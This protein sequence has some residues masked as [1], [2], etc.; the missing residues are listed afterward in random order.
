VSVNDPVAYTSQHVQ[1]TSPTDFSATSQPQPPTTIDATTTD[2][3]SNDTTTGGMFSNFNASDTAKQY[4]PQTVVGALQNAGFIDHDTS[5]TSSTLPSQETTF[6]GSRGGVGTLPGSW[7]EEGVAKLPEE[8]VAE[9][10]LGH[11][12]GREG[13]LGT[14]LEERPVGLMDVIQKERNTEPVTGVNTAAKF[15]NLDVLPTPQGTPGEGTTLTHA[16]PDNRDAELKTEPTPLNNGP[17]IASQR[18][19]DQVND[20]KAGNKP[21]MASQ[22][23]VDKAINKPLPPV[24]DGTNAGQKTDMSYAEDQQ[25][26]KAARTEPPQTYSPPTSPT[27]TSNT[28]AT[29]S[30]TTTSHTDATKSPTSTS[31]TDATKSHEKSTEKKASDASSDKSGSGKPSFTQKLKGEVKIIA[32]KIGKNPEKVEQGQAMKSGTA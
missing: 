27:T 26:R 8:K 14:D 10:K 17:A 1:N 25:K 23:E 19:H 16:V 21:S 6:S 30:S 3:K 11:E 5:V 7:Q 32:G 2:S 29:K 4:L 15:V 22:N 20:F 12:L 24:G 28:D 9:E 31:H 18:S 13:V